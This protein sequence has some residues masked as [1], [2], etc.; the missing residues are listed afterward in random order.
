ML[1]SLLRARACK[2]SQD[3]PHWDQGTNCRQFD[4]GAPAEHLLPTLTVHV[5]SVTQDALVRECEVYCTTTLTL[6]PL[7]ESGLSSQSELPAHVFRGIP[8]EVFYVTQT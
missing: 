3:L 5:W 7:L 6:Q 2:E 4:K 1:P 8:F